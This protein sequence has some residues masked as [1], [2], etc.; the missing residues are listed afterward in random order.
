VE[1]KGHFSGFFIKKL[2]DAGIEKHTGLFRTSGS[3]PAFYLAY[4][5]VREFGTTQ[6]HGLGAGTVLHGSQHLAIQTR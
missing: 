6:W 3:N 2:Y 1:R 4:I 5:P